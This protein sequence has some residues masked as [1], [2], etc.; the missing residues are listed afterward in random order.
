MSQVW[1]IAKRDLRAYFSSPIAYIV[2]ALFLGIMGWMF[3]WNLSFFN[4]QAMQYQRFPRGEGPS[5]SDGILRPL[6]GNMN[7][8]LLFLLP[9][10]TMR[11]VAEEKKNHTMELLL[12]S[13]LKVSQII[14]GKYLSGLLLLLVMLAL[15]WVYPITLYFTGNP[16]LGVI[17]GANLGTFLLASCYL[18]VGLLFSSMTENQIVAGALTFATLL[19][20]WLVGWA[21]NSAGSEVG[22]V[23]EYVSLIGHFKNFSRGLISSEDVVFYLSFTGIGL[24]LTHR[25]LDSYRWK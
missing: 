2:I 9:F 16:D 14:F 25:V 17:I 8:V 7:I 4:A 15:T 13:P 23:I 5:I 19:F 24:F 6:Y 1:N 12:T 18:S 10:V 22:K 20:F 3:F 21:S 11:L